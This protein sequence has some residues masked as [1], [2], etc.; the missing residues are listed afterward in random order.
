MVGVFTMLGLVLHTGLSGFLIHQLG[1]VQQQR[2]E[3]VVE[4]IQNWRKTPAGRSLFEEMDLRFSPLERGWLIRFVDA[5]G[6]L[7]YPSAS[8]AD[9][10]RGV[11][12]ANRAGTRQIELP[13]GERAMVGAARGPGGGWVEVAE[14]SEPILDKVSEVMIVYVAI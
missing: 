5:N 11:P 8:A 14:S 12:V 1:T 4:L 6:G 3:S 9:P 10:F 2:A 7:L 13:S